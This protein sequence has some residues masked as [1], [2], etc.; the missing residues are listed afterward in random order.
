MLLLDT[1]AIYRWLMCESLPETLIRRIEEEGALVSILAPWEMLVKH[2]VGKLELPTLDVATD[3]EAQGF[4][5]LPVRPPHLR[6]L[7][8]LPL[9]HRDPFDRLLIA[10]AKAENLTVVTADRIFPEYLP[11]TLLI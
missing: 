11:N 3:I 1:N 8:Q 7:G 10:Q 6:A 4:T 5:L 9:L 2:Q